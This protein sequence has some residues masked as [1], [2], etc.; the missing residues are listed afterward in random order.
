M[1]LIFLP[2]EMFVIVYGSEKVLPY[3]TKLHNDPHINV[4]FCINMSQAAQRCWPNSA[5]FAK[6]GDQK[7]QI[8]A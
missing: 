3:S 8:L 2:K 7:Y 1:Q 4:R 6:S 5:V